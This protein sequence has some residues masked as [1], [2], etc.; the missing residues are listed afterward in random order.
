MSRKIEWFCTALCRGGCHCR[1]AAMAAPAR[2]AGDRSPLVSQPVT[3]VG[4]REPSVFSGGSLTRWLSTTRARS[5]PSA[6][7]QADSRAT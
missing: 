7:A 5:T 3:E 2:W 6:D 4:G 1:G